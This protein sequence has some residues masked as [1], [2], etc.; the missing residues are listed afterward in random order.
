MWETIYLEREFNLVDVAKS[1]VL[2]YWII[3][4]PCHKYQTILR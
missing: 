4:D 3:S 2:D 1:T